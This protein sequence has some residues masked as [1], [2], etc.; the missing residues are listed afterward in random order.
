MKIV[1]VTV[2]FSAQG[3]P[4]STPVTLTNPRTTE[5][6]EEYRGIFGGVRIA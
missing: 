3:P 5:K 6:G 4:L 2:L 1:P